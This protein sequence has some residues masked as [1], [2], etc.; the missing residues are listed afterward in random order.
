MYDLRQVP[1]LLHLPPDAHLRGRVQKP[2]GI[3][4]ACVKINF[5]IILLDIRRQYGLRARKGEVLRVRRGGD[6]VR[7]QA[8]AA[9]RG[10]LRP[11]LWGTDG[12]LLQLHGRLHPD[13]GHGGGHHSVP[14]RGT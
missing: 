2:Y 14:Q 4:G 6:H 9:E 3:F 1:I 7:A 11:L 5:R 13:Q 8:S 12:N 10:L